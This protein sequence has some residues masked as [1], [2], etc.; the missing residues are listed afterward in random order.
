[1]SVGAE[2]YDGVAPTVGD[3]RSVVPDLHR[4]GLEPSNDP[5]VKRLRRDVSAIRPNDR[6]QLSVERDLSK[7]VGIGEWLKDAKPAPRREINLALR[8]I[9]ECQAEPMAS[10]YLDGRHVHEF[11]H[12]TMLRQRR[13]IP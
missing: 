10:H 9:L 5:A 7:V 13:T 12:V 2:T 3:E 4:A 8:S 11:V 1:M 6:S